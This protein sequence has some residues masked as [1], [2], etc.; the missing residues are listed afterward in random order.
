MHRG[1][2]DEMQVETHSVTRDWSERSGGGG[3]PDQRGDGSSVFQPWVMGWSCNFFAT[4]FAEYKS[5]RGRCATKTAISR[6]VK[7]GR[8]LRSLMPRT[9]Y[10]RS[11]R[12]DFF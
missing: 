12:A 1:T 7:S 3:G 2:Y 9:E 10:E 4:Q 6:I 8:K 5:T 11:P